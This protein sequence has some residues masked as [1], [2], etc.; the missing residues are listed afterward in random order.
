MNKP[1]TIMSVVGRLN[2]EIGRLKELGNL[3]AETLAT[4]DDG[5][6]V[7]AD[8]ESDLN[9]IFSDGDSYQADAFTSFLGK[10]QM[11]VPENVSVWVVLEEWD[12]DSGENGTSLYG[13]DTYES[14]LA[15]M[16]EKVDELKNS[17]DEWECDWQSD[18]EVWMKDCHDNK[19][20]L[21]I[22]RLDV[23]LCQ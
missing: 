21:T 20:T 10:T 18:S 12:L 1:V 8:A 4:L 16:Y 23:P 7:A 13:R 6:G 3:F 14:A 17:E 5:Q 22:E 9:G 11:V 15:L 19:T 2:G